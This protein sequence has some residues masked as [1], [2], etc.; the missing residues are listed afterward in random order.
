M[1]QHSDVPETSLESVMAASSLIEK[2]GRERLKPRKDEPSGASDVLVLDAALHAVLTVPGSGAVPRGAGGRGAHSR[3]GDFGRIQ[4]L[5]ARSRD[6]VQHRVR[7]SAV[8][9]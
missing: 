1:K 9:N 8:A 3:G 5:P 7:G 4:P 2:M 6:A